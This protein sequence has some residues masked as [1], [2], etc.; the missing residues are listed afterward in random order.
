MNQITIKVG[1]IV[2]PVCGMRID[3]AELNIIFALDD[4]TFHFCAE[5]CKQ[6]FEKCPQKYLT[7]KPRKKGVWGRY[8]DRLNK[9][10]GG[11]A[12]KCH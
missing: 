11:K 4:Q 1:N 8:M 5:A 7:S 3:P 2:D 12:M 10:T 6:A 9:A